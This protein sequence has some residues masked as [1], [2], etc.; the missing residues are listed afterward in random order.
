[1]ATAESKASADSELQHSFG[2][3]G[4]GFDFLPLELSSTAVD[5]PLPTKPA[6]KVPVIGL[7]S[8]GP[9]PPADAPRPTAESIREPTRKPGEIW[10]DGDVILCACLDCSAPMSVR[11]WLMMA[12]CWR[13]AA[14]I[15]LSEE[16]ERQVQQLLAERERQSVTV[17]APPRPPPTPAARQIA[18]P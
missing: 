7:E 18:Q 9:L 10:L 15:E 6:A 1:M 5:P 3:G 12:D 14:S 16:Q 4:V 17:T 2:L 8:S 13:C 11:F